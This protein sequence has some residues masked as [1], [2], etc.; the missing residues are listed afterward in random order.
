STTAPTDTDVIWV[1]PNETLPTGDPGGP[2]ELFGQG[3]PEG[4]VAAPVGSIYTDLNATNGAVRWIKKSGTGNVGWW[5]LTGDTGWR[6]VPLLNSMAGWTLRL[7]RI[8]D[9]VYL[10]HGT[11]FAFGLWKDVPH[12]AV[13]N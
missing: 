7:R 5:V 1:N 6:E 9:T 4:V 8:N 13:V 10:T 2:L 3:F 11:P 12:N